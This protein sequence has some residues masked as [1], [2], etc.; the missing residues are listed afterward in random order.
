MFTFGF[1]AIFVLTQLPGLPCLKRKHIGIRLI[2]LIIFIIN[3]VS[4]YVTVEKFTK[5]YVVLFIQ[6]LNILGQL[7]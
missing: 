5:P 4:V 2:P 3:Y 1:G 7:V 6:W